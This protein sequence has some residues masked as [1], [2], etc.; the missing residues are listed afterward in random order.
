MADRIE[1]FILGSSSAIVA[2]LLVYGL[3][4]GEIHGPR[5]AVFA[6]LASFLAVTC[7]VRL[8]LPAGESKGGGKR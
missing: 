3:V 8:A 6:A 1:A 7:A 2:G 4:T 5:Y